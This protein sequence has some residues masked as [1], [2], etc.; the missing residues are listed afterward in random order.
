MGRVRDSSSDDCVVFF[1]LFKSED[2]GSNPILVESMLLKN[3]CNQ[4]NLTFFLKKPLVWL[5]LIRLSIPKTASL[6]GNIILAMHFCGTSTPE[7]PISIC[8]PERTKGSEGLYTTHATT[9]I[10]KKYHRS[11]VTQK[12][13]DFPILSYLFTTMFFFKP[14][15]LSDPLFPAENPPWT[16]KN[17]C[18]FRDTLRLIKLWAKNRGVYSNVLGNLSG[19]VR[20]SGFGV[21]FFQ[22]PVKFEGAFLFGWT[23]KTWPDIERLY[24]DLWDS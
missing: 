14:P 17:C 11:C 4:K 9:N 12:I 21:F 10:R 20:M 1:W 24:Q 22:V 19:S 13:L 3:Y 7:P 6:N 15:N 16:T 5:K 8:H 2:S 23:S 18:R